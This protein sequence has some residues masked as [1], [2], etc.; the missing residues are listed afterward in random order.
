MDAMYDYIGVLQRINIDAIDFS[1]P[2]NLVEEHVTVRQLQHKALDLVVYDGYILSRPVPPI[3]RRYTWPIL[4]AAKRLRQQHT[5]LPYEATPIGRSL[6]IL[7]VPIYGDERI[8]GLQL[9]QTHPCYAIDNERR[10]TV[11]L[12]DNLF[13]YPEALPM[14]AI[15][16]AIQYQLHRMWDKRH[17]ND[18]LLNALTV[19]Y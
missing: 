9:G 10:W 13:S 4:K 3:V 18:Q 7:G 15:S 6:Q 14:S 5:P 17:S 16:H 12:S 1:S 11:W 2:D 19:E 8:R